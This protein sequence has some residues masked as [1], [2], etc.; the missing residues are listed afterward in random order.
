MTFVGAGKNDK[1]LAGVMS[2]LSLGDKAAGK[3]G[4]G[5]DLLDLMDGA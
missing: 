1:H 2:D 4:D 3:G 5:H